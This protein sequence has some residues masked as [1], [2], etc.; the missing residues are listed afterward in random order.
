MKINLTSLLTFESPTIKLKKE[1][2]NIPI[3]KRID[4]IIIEWGHTYRSSL[5][6]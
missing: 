2:K 5:Y 1:M 6:A 4:W 3:I